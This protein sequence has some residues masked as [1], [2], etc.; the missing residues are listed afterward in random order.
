MM[1]NPGSERKETRFLTAE[2]PDGEEVAVPLATVHGHEDGPVML[3]QAGCHGT[4]YDGIEAVK[5]LF[6][7]LDPDALAGTLI[8]VPCLNLP[9]FYGMTPH[10]N[11]ID[12]VNPGRA[13]PGDPKGT[14]TERMVALV[15]ELALGADYII[16]VHG[17][18]LEEELVDYSQ[19]NLTGNDEVDNAAASLALALDMPFFVRRPRPA[20]LPQSG[21]SLHLIGASNGKPSVLSESGSHG[22][23]NE[24]TVR[25]HLDSLRNALV[26]AGMIEGTLSTTNP[27][28]TVLHRFLGIA[29]PVDGFW[30][31]SVKKGEV[32]RKGQS[33]GEM[34]DVFHQPLADVVSDEDAAILGVISVVG[35]RQGEMLLGIGTL[36]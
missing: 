28:P 12:G 2:G 20:E 26:H 33:V 30:Y 4:E 23:L 3:V 14:H 24:A 16:D 5:R 6:Q 9:A 15:W 8:T 17:G 1:A 13:F 22:E 11:P 31:P 21:G 29:A 18:D 35:R 19:V 32:I 27:S 25:V 34:R 7:S 10:V 36:D